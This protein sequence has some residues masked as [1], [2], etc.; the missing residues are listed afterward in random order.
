M[1]SEQ[2]VETLPDYVVSSPPTLDV[3]TP[4]L[5]HQQF[6]TPL[7]ASSPSRQVFAAPLH[8]VVF[9][10]LLFAPLLSLHVVAFPP[11]RQVFAS[12]LLQRV[13]VTE[14]EVFAPLRPLHVVEAPDALA[15]PQLEHST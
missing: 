1:L 2:D 15:P 9:N 11:Q 5:L 3:V 14:H 4:P 7:D 6:F 12:P 10:E 13:V 8:Q